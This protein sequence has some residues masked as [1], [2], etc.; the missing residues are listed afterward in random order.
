MAII[1]CSYDCIHQSDG[2]CC[3]DEQSAI[4]NPTAQNG[5]CCVYYLKKNNDAPAAKEQQK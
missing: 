3:L 4:N 5:I 2:Y 1:Q